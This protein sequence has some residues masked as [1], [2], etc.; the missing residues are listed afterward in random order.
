MHLLANNYYP[1]G[2]G[3]ED[4]NCIDLSFAHAVGVFCKERYYDYCMVVSIQ[5]LFGIPSEYTPFDREKVLNFLGFVSLPLNNIVNDK[6]DSCTQI[7]LA[8]ESGCPV[9]LYTNYEC[10]YYSDV[11]KVSDQHTHAIL[12]TGYDIEKNIFILQDAEAVER[13]DIQFTKGQIY[14]KIRVKKEMLIDII[15]S[16]MQHYN[17]N[18]T[19]F[20]SDCLLK[21]KPIDE[22]KVQFDTRKTVLSLLISSIKSEI[23]LF[24]IECPFKDERTKS[25]IDEFFFYLRRPYLGGMRVILDYIKRTHCYTTN[26]VEYEKIAESVLSS[27]DFYISILHKACLK[28]P[29]TVPLRLEIYKKDIEAN[30]SR[31][32]NIIDI[33]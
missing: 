33:E 27:I 1:D 19:E 5:N 8:L 29:S 3:I 9:I 15:E 10:L 2:Y 17:M 30:I 16:T 6:I 23:M 18:E 4:V 21:I 12:I 20:Q 26:E 25:E 14:Y 7:A 28:N 24:E 31:L 11:Y 13:Y 32:A 22:S